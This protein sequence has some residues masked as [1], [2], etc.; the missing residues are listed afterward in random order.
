MK[1]NAANDDAVGSA[2]FF[3]LLYS[4]NRLSNMAHKKW[5]RMKAINE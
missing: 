1:L 2:V 4:A 3:R 5:I